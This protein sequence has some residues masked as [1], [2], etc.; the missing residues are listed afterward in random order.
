MLFKPPRLSVAPL[1]HP[2]ENLLLFPPPPEKS[3]IC[4][5]RRRRREKRSPNPHPTAAGG[6]SGPRASSAWVGVDLLTW[7]ETHRFTLL[8]RV[9]M[10]EYWEK[11][12]KIKKNLPNLASNKAGRMEG[13][14]WVMRGLGRNY[15]GIRALLLNSDSAKFLITV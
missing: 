13:W 12:K 1:P 7:E 15:T 4:Q 9:W 6:K 2:K 5:P 11:N 10:D 14:Y 3:K 8:R